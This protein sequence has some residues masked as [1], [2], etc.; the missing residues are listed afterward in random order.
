[1]G[2]DHFTKMENYIRVLEE[3]VAE[4]TGVDIIKVNA[5]VN[6]ADITNR[7]HF[8]ENI[9]VQKKAEVLTN[10]RHPLLDMVFNGIKSG[11]KKW[12][13]LYKEENQN[14]DGK[15]PSSEGW[16]TLPP[17]PFEY[18]ELDPFIKTSI[19]KTHHGFFHKEYVADYNEALRKYKI[20]EAKGDI[21][22]MNQCLYDIN[23]NGCAQINHCQFWT[24]L[25]PQKDGGGN[26]DLAPKVKAQIE[27][28]FGS[29]A[30]FR[31]EFI[32][33]GDLVKG[34]S[35]WTFL[36]WNM[37]LKKLEVQTTLIQD[38]CYEHLGLIPIISIDVGYPAYYTQYFSIAE[39]LD[40]GVMHV[41]NWPMIQIRFDDALEETKRHDKELAE[42]KAKKSA[43][44]AHPVSTWGSSWSCMKRA[45]SD[46]VK[47][48]KNDATD[49]LK[50]F[51]SFR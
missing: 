48:Y 26:V 18:H 40:Q 32:Y 49:M 31:E 17:L 33:K 24:S 28:D 3:K 13:T 42:K 51:Y 29:Y 43:Q 22:G 44:P 38:S 25:L 14:P 8:I 1:M 2:I 19:M 4:L 41:L 45:P 15:H 7:S 39:Y 37:D 27:K 34:G 16:C 20:Q 12:F 36:A 23:H 30:K 9:I 21:Y 47:D 5:N 46:D 10:Q 35:G 6:E 11:Q 50:D